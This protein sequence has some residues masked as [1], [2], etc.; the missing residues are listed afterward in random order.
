MNSFYG[1]RQGKSFIISKTYSSV[2]D[3]TNDF[4]KL[5]DCSVNFN[6]YVLINTEYKNNPE[7][8]RI[9]QRGY[10]YA[11]DRKIDSYVLNSTDALFTVN[12]INAYGAI[13]IGTIV[14]P[15]GPAPLI[16]FNTIEEIQNIACRLNISLQELNL[17][18]SATSDTILNALNNIC[19]K[20]YIDSLE[21]ASQY[22]FAQIKDVYYIFVDGSN[23]KWTMSNPL[24]NTPQN[25]DY[26]PGIKPAVT[27]KYLDNGEL[28]YWEDKQNASTGENGKKFLYPVH[29][30]MRDHIE[31]A[32]CTLRDAEQ[33]ETIAHVG[34]NLIAPTVEFVMDLIEAPEDAEYEP[35]ASIQRVFPDRSENVQTY[36]IATQ[37]DIENHPFYSAWKLTIP[38]RKVPPVFTDYFNEE[39]Y[40]STELSQRVQTVNTRLCIEEIVDE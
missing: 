25:S 20:E 13:Y 14:G 35:Q 24:F 23:P 36:R 30:E 9:Y 40:N 11:S 29:Q 34:L 15:S 31:W 10:D 32:A 6:E 7:N 38:Y 18:D 5:L 8:G 2:Q 3:M 26:K 27:Y 28:E 17:D 22:Y 19:D 16:E 33:K 12:S 37:E 4:Y 21:Y 39:D 1:G